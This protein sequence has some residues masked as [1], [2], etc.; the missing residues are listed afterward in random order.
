MRRSLLLAA[1]V[2]LTSVAS[3]AEPRVL[4]EDRLDG[5]PGEG[6][7]WLRENPLAW[8]TRAGG[9]EIRVEPGLAH[10]V[11]NALVRPAPDRKKAGCAV[12]VTV[13]FIAPP[14]NQY[15]QAGITWY[16]GDKPV[17]KFVHE[18]IDG[19]DYMI[20]GKVPAPAKTV[21]MRLQVTA[22]KYTA[23]FRP[24]AQGEFRTAAAG[25]LPPGDNER[26]SIQCYNGP[27]GAEHWF[28][29]SN[30]RIVEAP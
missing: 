5:K 21:Q 11:K 20:P 3:A 29:F 8:R 9:L 1:V 28:R 23:Q 26:V 2:L 18:H 30:F 24:D 4:F 27:P 16:H 15:E 22:D 13:T 25:K 12:E 7:I 10:N 6:W 19:K 17:F 14:T